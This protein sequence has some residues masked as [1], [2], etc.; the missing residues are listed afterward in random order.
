MYSVVECSVQ[1]AE[2]LSVINITACSFQYISIEYTKLQ[3]YKV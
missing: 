3:G 2:N 1:N